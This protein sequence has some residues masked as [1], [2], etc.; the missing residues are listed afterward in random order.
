MLAVVSTQPG[1]ARS[2]E[3]VVEPRLR[4]VRWPHVVLITLAAAGIALLAHA[5]PLT[6]DEAYNRLVYGKLGVLGI[7]RTYDAPNNHLLFTVLQS[8]IPDRLLR[9]DPWTIRI[10][11]VA[12]GIAMV[13]AVIGVAAARRTT[14]FL[15]LFAVFGSPLLVS[16]L[17]VSRGYTFS[18]VLLV[19]AAA[20]PV[21][22]ARRHA[23]L[24]VCAGA[25]ALALGTWPVPTNGFVAPGW[26]IAVLA[27]WGLRAA[28]AGTAVYAAAATAMFAP[29]AGQ[30]YRQAKHPWNA[31]QHW[32]P[33]VGDLFAATSLV[34]VCLV[35]VGAIAVA[36]AVRERR[37]RSP[38]GIRALGDD[39]HLAI[40]ALAMSVSWLMSVGYT[41]AFGVQ[42]PFVRS[43]IPAM[44]LGVVA[45]VAAFPRGRLEYVAVGLLVPAL[46][47]AALMWTRAVRHGDWEQVSRKSRNDVLFGTTPATIRDLP[48]IGAG[49]IACPDYDSWVCQLVAPYLERRGVTVD[50]PTGAVAYDSNLRCALGS[51]R[52][53][54][55]FQ[56]S[57]YRRGKLVGV[58]CH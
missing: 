37:G 7:L 24:G 10:F 50:A 22:L 42:L 56:V 12:S 39:T 15:G 55:P 25:A 45:V 20:L 33:W 5:A 32:W 26:I 46:V 34:P 17:F 19:A 1:T 30:V 29:I 36:A 11:G 48:S 4:A 2:A 9:W 35:L 47:L 13:A 16:Y 27:V 38:A 40:L 58:L 41:H 8:F 57:V 23:T 52:A 49:R 44:W 51:R 18:A 6:Y 21:V 31:N 28:I 54:D 3:R 43:A 53:P 14:P